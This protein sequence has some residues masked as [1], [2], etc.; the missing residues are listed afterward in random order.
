MDTAAV[1]SGSA[2]AGEPEPSAFSSE[3]DAFERE[4]EPEPA[5]ESDSARPAFS[6]RDAFG[7]ESGSNFAAEAGSWSAGTAEPDE[8]EPEL[9]LAADAEVGPETADEAEHEA[10]ADAEPLA[11]RAR[12][13]W[14]ERGAGPG[15]AA[16]AEPVES[17]SWGDR[18]FTPVD[19]AVTWGA[20]FGAEETAALPV[21]AERTAFVEPVAPAENNH[22]G[23]AEP[24]PLAE[25]VQPDFAEPTEPRIEPEVEPQGD[26]ELPVEEEPRGYAERAE[27]AAEA[28]PTGHGPAAEVEPP[29]YQPE[30]PV[31]VAPSDVESQGYVEPPAELEA[32]ATEVESRGY[33]EPE[34]PV[35]VAPSDVEP[36]GYVEVDALGYGETA[37][38][39][40]PGYAEVE[41]SGYGET[42]A[43]VEYVEPDSS[44]EVASS[45]VE[46]PNLEVEAEPSER[47]E[48]ERPG[49]VDP[50]T[51]VGFSPVG[52][53]PGEM[54]TRLPVP[55]S[56]TVPTRRPPAP[57]PPVI[58]TPPSRP[59]PKRQAPPR[60]AGPPPSGIPGS[61]E[62]T[63]F[64]SR[65]P[66][67]PVPVRSGPPP[68]RP[69]Q[70]EPPE[71]VRS[72]PVVDDS[73]RQ[74]PPPE[75]TPSAPE[76]EPARPRRRKGVL[77]GGVIA[78]V[79]ALGAGAVVAVPGLAAKIGLASGE[80]EVQIAPPA[81][82]VQF[83]PTLRGPGADVPAPSAAGVQAA[84]AGAVASPALGTLT[85]TVIDP[86]TGKVLFERNPTTPLIPASTIKLLTTAAA[87]LALP[88]S[89]QLSTKV[90]AGDKPGTV[91]IVGGGDPTLSS[92]AAGKES[93]YPGAAHLD[94]LVAQVKA[95]GPVDTVMVDLERYQGDF[96]AQGWDP[97]DVP[98]GHIAPIV[99]AMMD[100]GR[101]DPTKA[102]VART[103]NPARA[104]AEAFAKRIGAKVPAS[105]LAKA[106]PDAKVLGEVKS[107]P[108]VE[109]VDTVLQRSDNVLAEV[110]AREVAKA[111]NKEASFAGGTGA[112]LDTLR[113]NGFDVTGV[114]M[115]DGSGLS[116][117]DKA[118][119]AL[120]ADVLRVA[121]AP[122]GSDPRTVKLRPLLGGLPVAGGSGT[123]A[124]RYADPAASGGRG[125][126]RAKTGTL[127]ASG[128]NSLAGVVLDKDGRL[129]VFAMVT[130][131]SDTGQ[132]QPALDVV[133][134]T[135]RQCGC[136]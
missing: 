99:P 130:N 1:G 8:L 59:A 32:S 52:P 98:G 25:A 14:L 94:E 110:L 76:P 117:L 18:P 64:L 4:A 7:R 58:R 129:L 55:D 71:V 53:R 10:E 61:A 17:G 5:V 95:A 85:G 113:N 54:T 81:P 107:A 38:V 41:S 92:L 90:V 69:R 82:P 9:G 112:V 70:A 19:Q 125:W 134:A 108:M 127:G 46:A 100:G 24:E 75:S 126:V 51:V 118:T 15:V 83:T 78:A 84:V 21:N 34:S 60:P 103:D 114:A 122:D 23:S 62:E 101:A 42:A 49:Y 6:S 96:M 72:G 104:L 56:K 50:P 36:Q 37:T 39:E 29:D 128:V 57:P 93:V 47:V 43:E 63:Q 73:P 67:P 31:E 123:L 121:A 91:V 16:E 105:A 26:I 124:T 116:T 131:G 40:S 66:S 111:T 27:S 20:T 12:D 48:P 120:L 88:H 30:S 119:A 68:V 133:A 97:R 45:D 135:L 3:P 44:V 77:V 22:A 115:S 106:K 74:G 87:L 28:R 35:E 2:L 136:Q 79:V 13:S 11:E 102:T 89:E 33:V 132:A 86:T 109:L 65:P 80:P